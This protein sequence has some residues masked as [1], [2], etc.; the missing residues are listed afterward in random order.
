M[1]IQRR[2]MKAPVLQRLFLLLASNLL[3][4]TQVRRNM[5]RERPESEAGLTALYI[6]DAEGVKAAQNGEP[7]ALDRSGG[8][9]GLG[10]SLSCKLVSQTSCFSLSPAAPLAA[11]PSRRPHL[12]HTR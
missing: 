3:E 4:S 2:A 1:F 9:V 11:L 6:F 7:V 5:M 8:F 10:V 12:T